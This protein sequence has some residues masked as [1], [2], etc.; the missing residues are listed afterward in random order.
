M[1]I[2][3]SCEVTRWKCWITLKVMFKTCF[4]MSTFSSNCHGNWCKHWST[5]QVTVTY[6]NRQLINVVTDL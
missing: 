1:Y 3:E 6:N 4:V 5:V 2:L